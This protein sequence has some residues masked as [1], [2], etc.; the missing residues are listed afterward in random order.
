MTD[1]TLDKCA[2]AAYEAIRNGDFD[3]EEWSKLTWEAQQEFKRI[4][5]AAVDAYNEAVARLG[6]TEDY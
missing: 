6:E 3:T 1:I 2:K 5:K 4:A